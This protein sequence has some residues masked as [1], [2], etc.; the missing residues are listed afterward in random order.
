MYEALQSVD[1]KVT[2]SITLTRRVKIVGISLVWK[3]MFKYHYFYC[4]VFLFFMFSVAEAKRPLRYGDMI[5]LRSEKY[6]APLYMLPPAAKGADS[7]LLAFQGNHLDNWWIVKGPFRKDRE[8]IELLGKPVK[9]NDVVRLEHVRHRA[10]VREK[11]QGTSRMVVGGNKGPGFMNYEDYAGDDNNSDWVIQLQLDGGDKREE[12]QQEDIVRLQHINGQYLAV[13]DQ[14]YQIPTAPQYK[15]PPLQ[16]NVVVT[17]DES[18]QT[19]RSRW[20]MVDVISLPALHSIR[21]N[22]KSQERKERA[23]L[24]VSFPDKDRP[25][26]L[27]AN[28]KDQ[29]EPFLTMSESN[30][31]LSDMIK[32][33]KFILKRK[34]AKLALQQ[35]NLTCQSSPG[36]FIVSFK[37]GN[38]TLPQEIWWPSPIVSRDGPWKELANNGF[39][40]IMNHATKGFLASPLNFSEESELPL[41]TGWAQGGKDKN[42]VGPAR[43][44]NAL[45][46]LVL[47]FDSYDVPFYDLTAEGDKTSYYPGIHSP[48]GMIFHEK[49]KLP[50]KAQGTIQFSAQ[51]DHSISLALSSDKMVL[52][53]NM[54]YI[55]IGGKDNSNVSIRKG[56]YGAELDL[57]STVTVRRDE[58]PIKIQNEDSKEKLFNDYWITINKRMIGDALSEST[59][60]FGTGT[61]PGKDLWMIWRDKEPLPLVEY[62]GFGGGEV[63]VTF[64]SISF[65][66]LPEDQ[67]ITSQQETVT[68]PAGYVLMPSDIEKTIF[69]KDI[70]ED[71]TI[72]EV[73]VGAREGRLI[74][75]GLLS[76]GSLVQY[77]SKIKKWTI[78]VAKDDK[79]RDIENM[80]SCSLSIDGRLYA[81]ADGAIYQ[82]NWEANKWNV[83]Q[84]NKE[85][86]VITDVSVGKGDNLWAFDSTSK[87]LYQ[88][89]NQK[90]EQRS[91]RAIDFAV[92]FDGTV[93]ALNDEGKPF[94]YE[95]ETK[96]WKKLSSQF[97]KEAGLEESVVFEKIIVQ[98]SNTLYAITRDMQFVLYDQKA[99]KWNS[100]LDDEKKPI[101]NILFCAV[102]AAGTIC[103]RSKNNDLYRKGD[104]GVSPQAYALRITGMPM[105]KVQPSRY[106]IA[107]RDPSKDKSDDDS[108]MNK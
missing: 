68:L 31:D 87:K 13:S 63:P 5:Q 2:K 10:Y 48:F 16:G 91:N 24:L 106:G 69:A 98:N 93:A 20:Q 90:W 36:S 73:A 1:L 40:N 89:V 49:W 103:L 86:A 99:E 23:V 45:S 3:Y 100:V 64:K 92:A 19:D 74:L 46:L 80:T 14:G 15:G 4:I 75:W 7:V 8:M 38:F 102:N 79:G 105:N 21:S 57:V 58:K 95:P 66:A 53:N 82:Y 94:L 28:K 108:G 12:L 29:G 78:H 32:K 101:N 96:Q 62:V 81:A 83:V 65:K 77:D 88:R 84:F 59:I 34:K 41:K 61:V 71:D 27:Y 17:L 30:N 72:K 52:Q 26:I 50:H 11:F 44:A 35:A 54:Y 25:R 6:Q 107:L 51:A 55:C 47:D 18:Q 85:K 76:S 70:Q 33:G 97:L 56:M 104:K 9:N 67:L 42:F 37:P 39:I 22:D 43:T 60:S